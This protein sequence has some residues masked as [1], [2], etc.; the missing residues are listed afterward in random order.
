[1][2]FCLPVGQTWQ[3]TYI[4]LGALLFIQEPTLVAFLVV[5]AKILHVQLFS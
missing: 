2:A 1:M 4:G 3:G 5:P